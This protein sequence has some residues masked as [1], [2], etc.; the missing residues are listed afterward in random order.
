[1]DLSLLTIFIMLS[2]VCS[3]NAGLEGAAARR[4]EPSFFT[5]GTAAWL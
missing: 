1:M 5:F 4:K 2:I 3:S